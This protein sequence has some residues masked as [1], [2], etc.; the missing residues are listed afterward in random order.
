[1]QRLCTVLNVFCCI[2]LHDT[3]FC[4]TVPGVF[5][6]IVLL[7]MD[8]TVVCIYYTPCMHVLPMS[9]RVRSKESSIYFNFLGTAA[10]LSVMFHEIPHEISDFSILVE[11]GL[12]YCTMYTHTYIHVHTYRLLSAYCVPVVFSVRAYVR[13]HLMLFVL[14]LRCT[15][16]FSMDHHLQLHR[17]ICR[18]SRSILTNDILIFCVL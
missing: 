8:S 10:A 4:C 16:L 7:F 6:G 18:H 12:R 3:S 2:E 15:A 17:P 1:M 5:H 9:D 11:S 13:Y 14:L